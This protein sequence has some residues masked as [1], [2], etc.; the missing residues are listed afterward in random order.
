MKYYFVYLNVV[1]VYIY[2]IW[3]PPHDLPRNI[4]YGNFHINHGDAMKPDK[5]HRGVPLNPLK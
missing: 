1:P 3:S 4:L 2:I 5:S